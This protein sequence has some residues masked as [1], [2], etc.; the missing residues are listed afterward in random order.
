MLARP[1]GA[2]WGAP[3]G[4]GRLTDDPT[5]GAAVESEGA[6]D[7]FIRES[8]IVRGTSVPERC[9]RGVFQQDC[10]LGVVKPHGRLGPLRSEHFAVRPRAA[11]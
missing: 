10:S 9:D 6:E 11:Y 1:C 5:A 4:V 3:R 8:W 2:R 7:G